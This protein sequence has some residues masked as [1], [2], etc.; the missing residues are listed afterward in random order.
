M[1]P[2]QVENREYPFTGM[3][4]NDSKFLETGESRFICRRC[5]K[6]RKYFC[7]NCNL[8]LEELED[9][10]PKVKVCLGGF[11]T[12]RVDVKNDKFF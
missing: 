10:I 1:H 2:A 8:A 12:I 3:K 4:I 7:Y 9:R 6:S 5:F 11:L